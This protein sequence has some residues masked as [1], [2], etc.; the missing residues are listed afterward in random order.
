M[1]KRIAPSIAAALV[2]LLL[3]ACEQKKQEAPVSASSQ[4]APGSV[5]DS[6]LHWIPTDPNRKFEFIFRAYAPTDALFQKTWVLPDVERV[7]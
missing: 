7:Q 3:A 1:M 6:L 4:N 2:M 5:N